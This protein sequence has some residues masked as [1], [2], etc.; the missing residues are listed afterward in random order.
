MQ[1]FFELS[2][3][4]PLTKESTPTMRDDEG[5]KL[6]RILTIVLAFWVLGKWSSGGLSKTTDDGRWT[7]GS[8]RRAE[9]GGARVG[10]RRRTNDEGRSGFLCVWG[11]AGKWGVDDGRWTTG[12]VQKRAWGGDDEGR[13]TEDGCV[14]RPPVPA[15]YL[16]AP[17]LCI[18]LS[19]LIIQ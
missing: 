16:T 8:G 19:I 15:W 5:V 12:E 6:D 4:P 14:R 11:K 3:H 13:N 9:D 1:R 7:T 10:E 17:Y 2:W 18:I